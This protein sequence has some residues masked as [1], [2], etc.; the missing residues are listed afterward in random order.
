MKRQARWWG[1]ALALGAVATMGFLA[2][3]S[4]AGGAKKLIGE[5]AK[6]GDLLKKGDKAGATKMAQATAKNLEEFYECMELFK[7][8]KKG[9]IGVGDKAGAIIPDGIELKLITLGRDAPSASALAKEAEA[10]EDMAYHTAVLAEITLARAPKADKGKA[11]VK[12]WVEWSN[13]MKEG[14]MLLA[15]AAK[16]KAAA[17]VKAAAAKINASCNSCHSIFRN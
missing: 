10:L 16:A 15:A 13:D 2:A 6:A 1:V 12:D 8:R 5:I 11:R 4:Q 7:P 17:D 14:S 9:G 3:R